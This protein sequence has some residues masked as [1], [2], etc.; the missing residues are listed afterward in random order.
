VLRFENLLFGVKEEVNFCVPCYDRNL[1]T[2]VGSGLQLGQ[3]KMF[4]NESWSQEIQIYK[5]LKPYKEYINYTIYPN[6]I[7]WY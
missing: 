6:L 1:H 2:L 3:N 7:A 4:F 5:K